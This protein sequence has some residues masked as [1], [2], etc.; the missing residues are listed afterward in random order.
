MYISKELRK[1]LTEWYEHATKKQQTPP[2]KNHAGLCANIVLWCDYYRYEG[3]Q[4]IYEE[5]IRML[6]DEYGVND[7]PFGKEDYLWRS[8]AK[9]QQYNMERV[10]WVRKKLGL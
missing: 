6:Y 9:N 4:R 10:N 3:R 7:Y 1:F 2:F 8:R 5:L